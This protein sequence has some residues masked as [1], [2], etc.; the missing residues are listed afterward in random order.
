MIRRIGFSDEHAVHVAAESSDRTGTA[1][2]KHRNG[3]RVAARFI[4][5]ALRNAGSERTLNGG[6]HQLGISAHHRFGID[7]L[8]AEQHLKP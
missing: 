7:D 2:F 6:F 8:R 5:K 1:G 3:A 4:N